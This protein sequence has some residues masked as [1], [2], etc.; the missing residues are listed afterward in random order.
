MG[1]A[2]SWN[3]RRL[4]IPSA[5]DPLNRHPTNAPPRQMLT[6]RPETQDTQLLPC[7]I[8]SNFTR[9]V[10]AYLPSARVFPA[11]PRSVE[12]LSS[13]SFT[14]LHQTN[15]SHARAP[16]RELGKQ[17]Q[18]EEEMR[19]WMARTRSGSRRGR[20]W[21]WRRTRAAATCA[22]TGPRRPPFSLQK[23]PPSTEKK[24]TSKS[25]HPKKI[26]REKKEKKPCTDLA[27]RRRDP[28][29]RPWTARACTPTT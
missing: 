20:R 6:T 4:P 13:G 21:A 26:R 25:H 1:S 7:P 2:L 15:Q 22:T 8:T 5:M 19:K 16:H 29:R 3:A 27:S 11:K 17:P 10:A 14:T 18:P 28:W 24:K 23:P 9:I 12:M